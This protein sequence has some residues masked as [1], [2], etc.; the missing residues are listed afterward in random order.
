MSLTVDRNDS[1]IE[2]P[3]VTKARYAATDF[4]GVVSS[5]L[6]SPLA[7]C[8]VGDDDP[9]VGQH[10]FDHAKAQRKAEIQPHRFGNNLR[11]KAM[12]VI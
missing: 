11:R 1:L 3:F 2:V 8:L 5:E 7:H 4:I 10:V 9:S 6:F 12:A